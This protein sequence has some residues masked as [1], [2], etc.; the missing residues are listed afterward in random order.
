MQP[1][2]PSL[3]ARCGAEVLGTFILVL[4]GCGSVHVAVLTGDL[5]LGQVAMVWGIAIMLAA[6]CVGGISGA[7][8][9]PAMTLAL[10]A[11]GRFAWRDVPGYI[12]AQLAGT[13][14]AAAAL[15]GLFHPMLDEKEN[16]RS[17]SRGQPGS[18]ITAMCYGEYYP[19]PGKF[20]GGA[21]RYDPH[22]H[23][24]HYTLV[25]QPM[26]FLAEFLGTAILALMV[27]ALTDAR[28]PAAP[29]AR[30]APVFIGLTVAIL[31][32]VIAPLTQA[33]FNPARD[34]GPR[35]VAYFTGWGDI[36]IPGP[37]G[38]G[39]F[40]VYI[41]APIA[42]AVAGGGLYTSVLR[43]CLPVAVEESKTT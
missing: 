26:A 17:V 25:T 19:N 39:F 36:A 23:A 32:S 14:L 18:E 20:A 2:P 35:L 9:N 30:L 13:I 7:H 12:G 34:F 24:F 15:Y 3:S 37:N 43:P 41:L 40:T 4:F 10:A 11:W 16:I 28:N 6:Y 42:G 21:G 22:E 31:I 33:C 27:F 38:S 8:I 29:Q 5:G 1:A